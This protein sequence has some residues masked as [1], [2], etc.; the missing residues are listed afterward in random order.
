MLPDGIYASMSLAFS[1][2]S[3][4][5]VGLS[6]LVSAIALAAIGGVATGV[7]IFAGKRLSESADKAFVQVELLVR[8]QRGTGVPALA[9]FVAGVG[10]ALSGVFLSKWVGCGVALAG[11]L[12]TY[13]FDSLAQN[14][15]AK[16]DAVR[17]AFAIGAVLP[18][19]VIVAVPI[20][21]GGFGEV[22]IEM[23]V[24]GVGAVVVGMLGAASGIVASWERRSGEL[25]S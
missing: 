25:E 23:E 9:T 4:F 10:A 3:W 24:L 19:A 18:L 11:A 6:W 21:T 20:V 15:K 5:S 7:F 13:M 12:L 22:D 16:V 14:S 2:A 17:W 1:W 8:K